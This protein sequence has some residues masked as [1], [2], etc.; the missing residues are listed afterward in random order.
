MKRKANKKGFTLV[1]V[2]IAMSV[3]AVISTGFIMSASYA[4]K[5]QIKARRRLTTSNNQTTNLED[6][7]G[8]VDPTYAGM[9]DAKGIT[10]LGVQRIGSETGKWVMTYDFGPKGTLVNDK[11][12][13]YYSTPDMNDDVFQLTYFSPADTVALDA[14]EYWVTLINNSDDVAKDLPCMITCSDGCVLF[15]NEKEVFAGKTSM[16]GRILAG[17]GFK[18]SFGVKDVSGTY[19]PGADI[20]IKEPIGGGGIITSITDLNA[21]DADGDHHITISYNKDTNSFVCS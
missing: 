11:M 16:P 8:V 14:G 18:M 2:I 4:Y 10:D 20:I 3:F 7:R 12:Y 9:Y 19:G 21:K 5:A 15:N 6:Y 13:G 1:E 17:G